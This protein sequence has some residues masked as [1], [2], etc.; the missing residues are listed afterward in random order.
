LC[1][2]RRPKIPCARR[3]SP[4]SSPTAPWPAAAAPG[5]RTCR[6]ARR[7]GRRRQHREPVLFARRDADGELGQQHG[8]VVAQLAVP[9]SLEHPEPLH[10]LGAER[11]HA[12]EVVVFDVELPEPFIS[13]RNGDMLLLRRLDPRSSTSSSGSVE[14]VSGMPP[15]RMFIDKSRVVREMRSPMEAGI[16]R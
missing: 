13:A 10:K 1:R 11:H 3:R 7:R 16:S 15:D 6:T 8:P 9:G 12:V 5:T 14:T 4:R 2:S